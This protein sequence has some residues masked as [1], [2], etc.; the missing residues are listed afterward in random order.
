MHK[1]TYRLFQ[2]ESNRFEIECKM[3]DRNLNKNKHFPIAKTSGEER[4]RF[5]SEEK[6]VRD[7]ISFYDLYIAI[8]FI[9]RS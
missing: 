5:W 2:R 8:R 6:R 1:N 3:S 4:L 9:N 7:T